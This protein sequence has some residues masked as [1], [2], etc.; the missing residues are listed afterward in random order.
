MIDLKIVLVIVGVFLTFFV[1]VFYI[2]D[3]LA[4]RTKPHVFSWLVWSITTGIIY[5]LQV[6]AGAG[7]GSYITLALLAIVLLV[8]CLS[9][10]NGKKVIK[11]IDVV[12]LCLALLSV[13][14]WLVVHQPV[15]SIILLCAIDLFGFM[16]TIRKSWNDPYSETLSLYVITVFRYGLGFFALAEYNIVTWLFPITWVFGNAVFATILIIRRKRL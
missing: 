7:S 10:K 5:A 14:L 6:S 16:P 3:I 9:L 1:Y 15:L 2:R 11:K 8:F 13:P 4:G 12:F